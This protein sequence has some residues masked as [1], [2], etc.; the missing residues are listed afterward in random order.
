MQGIHLLTMH[1]HSL[2]TV[3]SVINTERKSLVCDRQM[4]VMSECECVRV[5]VCVWLPVS[6]LDIKLRQPK[7]LQELELQPVLASHAH[8]RV[9]C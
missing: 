1:I 8:V 4:G 9:F 2:H 7:Q 3:C 5:Y 6:L